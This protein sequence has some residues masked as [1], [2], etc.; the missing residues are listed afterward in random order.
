A[1]PIHGSWHTSNSKVYSYSL[2]N[3][4][5]AVPDER[6]LDHARGKRAI[7]HAHADLVTH[8]SLQRHSRECNRTTERRRERAGGDL[9]RRRGRAHAL[10]RAQHALVDEQQPGLL[11][12]RRVGKQR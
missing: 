4:N 7:A 5:F 11:E 3:E 8:T 6:R 9:P 10:M 12:S 2:L 1:A